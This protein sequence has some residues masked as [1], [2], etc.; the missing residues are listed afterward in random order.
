MRG[1]YDHAATLCMENKTNM[2]STAARFILTS[3]YPRGQIICS[4]SV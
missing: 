3:L 2:Y 4:R 1:V